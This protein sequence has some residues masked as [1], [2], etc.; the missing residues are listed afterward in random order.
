MR[1]ASD[2]R[3]MTAEDVTFLIRQTLD[4]SGNVQRR[5]PRE[6]E[7]ATQEFPSRLPAHFNL[8]VDALDHVWVQEHPRAEA[9]NPPWHIVRPD[10]VWL[11]A[12]TMPSPARPFEIGVDYVLA[13]RTASGGGEEVV[14]FS[15]RR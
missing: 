8:L 7:L 10:G 1:L 6:R 11:G 5:A 9:P 3:A 2:D 12:R 14:R 4:S 13:L 15:L